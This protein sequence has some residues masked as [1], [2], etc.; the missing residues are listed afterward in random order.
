MGS[1]SDFLMC[2]LPELKRSDSIENPSQCVHG[3]GYL[4]DLNSGNWVVEV[5]RD[6]AGVSVR[7]ELSG[8]SCS[9]MWL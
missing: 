9:D 8:S 7:A 5:V 1:T 6:V 2:Y 3:G 4:S